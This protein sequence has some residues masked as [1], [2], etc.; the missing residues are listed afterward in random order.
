MVPGTLNW[1]SCSCSL[2][3][4]LCSDWFNICFFSSNKNPKSSFTS[5]SKNHNQEPLWTQTAISPSV[6]KCHF[7]NID[8]FLLLNWKSAFSEVPQKSQRLDC[9][10]EI[11]RTLPR[12][13]RMTLAALI[14]HLYRWATKW[15]SS[16]CASSTS[17][18]TGLNPVFTLRV[19]KC[20]DL[21]Q[22]CTKNLSLLFAPSL[23]Q[24]DGKGEH[25]VKIVEDLIDNY[26]YVFDVS[27]AS[28]QFLF[29]DENWT[30]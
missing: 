12:V 23:F 8:H 25:E 30:N 10:K 15:R 28:V 18:R 13:N 14:S 17:P 20:A 26:L 16:D 4:T 21:N 27:K 11:I 6:Q 22:M 5:L 24:T 19:Q 3:M 1:R 29:L 9:Y 2:K 7:L